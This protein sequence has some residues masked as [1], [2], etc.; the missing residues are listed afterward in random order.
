VVKTLTT[1]D[2]ALFDERTTAYRI[3]DTLPDSGAILKPRF[4]SHHDNPL[5]VEHRYE[6][7]SYMDYCPLGTL[8]DII[9]NYSAED[10]QSDTDDQIPEPMFWIVLNM[11]SEAIYN[12]TSGL[13]Y[14][15]GVQDEAEAIGWLP[16]VH[17]DIKPANIFLMEPQE[18]YISFPRPVL[19][20][21][22]DLLELVGYEEFARKYYLHTPG[23]AAPENN[24]DLQTKDPDHRGFG[25]FFRQPLS[26]KTDIW[27]VGTI[28]WEMMHTFLGP[29]KIQNPW[30]A[31][32]TNTI[33][34]DPQQS[35]FLTHN[36]PILAPT[37]DEP[38]L[39]RDLMKIFEL[40]NQSMPA[41]RPTAINLRKLV[42]RKMKRAQ[43]CLGSFE[44]HVD[45]RMRV[46]YK[47]DEFGITPDVGPR[48]RRL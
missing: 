17:R 16:K 25:Y 32:I 48:H 37:L 31:A 30:H 26:C 47:R 8:G 1:S 3:I 35:R 29:Y 22:D 21:L 38:N 41:R 10:W 7:R 13:T 44:G 5:N 27:S 20:D 12:L 14:T 23:Y 19:A 24:A 45:E 40:C 39:T 4:W 15:P 11:L 28:L 33:H 2:K 6:V 43:K 42:V 34:P 46:R 18:P 36:L 9:D